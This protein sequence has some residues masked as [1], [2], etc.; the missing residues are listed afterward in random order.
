[1]RPL[2][3]CWRVGQRK[4]WY[5]MGMMAAK[6]FLRSTFIPRLVCWKGFRFRYSQKMNS[7]YSAVVFIGQHAM[8]G[9]EKGV[10]A[11]SYSSDAVQNISVKQ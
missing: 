9:A 10:L 6:P 7:S 11:H 4:S 5:G 8:A 2:M 1:M 3:A